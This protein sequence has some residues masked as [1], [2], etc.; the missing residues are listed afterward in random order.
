MILMYHKVFLESLTEWWVDA[1]NFYRQMCE[2]KCKKI[3]YLDDYD[4]TN[5]EHVVITFD[6][7]YK[8]IVEYALP[9]LEKF[10]YPFEVFITSDYIGKGNEFDTTEPNADF[11][12]YDDLNKLATH[13]GRIQW[14]TKSHINL[15]YM[16]D[17]NKIIEELLV[18]DELLALGNNSFKWFAYPYGDFNNTVV[19]EAKKIFRGAVSCNQGNDSDRYKLNRITVI[20]DTSF[21]KGTISVIIASYNY[22]SFLVEAIESV[23]RQTRPVDEILISDDFSQDNTMDIGLEY[24]KKYPSIIK[25]NRND[26]NLGIVDHFNKAVSLTKSDYICFLGADNR[27]RS[28]YIEKTAEILDS[29][30]SIAVAYTDFALFGQRAKLV[31]SEFPDNRKGPI[32]NDYYYI[33]NF[34]EFNRNELDKGNFIHGSSLYKRSAFYD[35]GGYRQKDEVPEDYNLFLNMIKKGWGAKGVSEPLLEYR[36]HST[37]QANV[38]LSSYAELNFYKKQ[39]NILNEFINEQNNAS[40]IKDQE[41]AIQIE[42]IKD[43]SERERVLNSELINIS[44][45][46]Y[47]MKLRLEILDKSFLFRII[48]K[49]LIYKDRAKNKYRKDG[50]LGLIKSVVKKF[51]K[52]IVPRFIIEKY[53]YKLKKTDFEGVQNSISKNNGKVIIVFPVI[54]WNFRW[55]RPQ[56]IISEFAK[57]GYTVIYLS[58]DIKSRGYVYSNEKQAELDI[59]IFNLQEGIFELHLFGSSKF[60]IYRD[61]LDC[62]NLN[63]LYNGF[64]SFVKNIKLNELT[65]VVQHPGWSRLVFKLSS[66]LAGKVIF[67][68]MDDHSGF[69]GNSKDALNDEEYLLK[70]SDLIIVTSK[71]L[72]DKAKKENKNVILVRNG[73]DFSHFNNPCPNGELDYLKGK[74]IIG[75]YGAIAEWFDIK[76]FEYC[77]RQKPDWN[78]VLIGAINGCDTSRVKD[79]SNVYF[80]GEKQYKDLP[81]Y[82]YYFDVCTIPFKIIPLTLATNPVK[83]YE[84]I[85]CGKPM[86]SVRLPELEQYSEYCYLADDK[87]DFLNKLEV[88]L[89]EN[90][91][92]LANKRIQL[93]RNNSWHARFKQIRKEFDVI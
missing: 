74:P 43:L 75:Y 36:Q 56:H 40:L 25:F 42:K 30:N 1:D 63:N 64:C 18:P 41:I 9:I 52:K 69:D 82:L 12:S 71:L 2:L 90:D 58:L 32:V 60:S 91:I 21:K 6:G 37:I 88:A 22:G 77:A 51:L 39:F 27:F 31:Y 55:Q 38:S 35:V 54:P 20:N 59:S 68:C 8:N 49:I 93:A 34:P 50:I 23:L 47:G 3:V 87:E 7:G 33:I 48:E 45:W 65:Y 72:E 16:V 70:N 15:S 29:N 73:T 28:D 66:S 11:A 83:F 14:H 86:V 24:A 57:N 19:D 53:K 44:D 67:D 76:L 79:L 61:R 17:K 46:A 10:N 92:E 81:G 13:G 84:Y 62:G 5:P 78:F 26:H 89:S 85:S 80:L 4:P